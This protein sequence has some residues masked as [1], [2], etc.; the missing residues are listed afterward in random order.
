MPIFRTT[1][2]TALLSVLFMTS[3]QAATAHLDAGADC[4]AQ[5]GY[6]LYY[7]ET[8]WAGNSSTSSTTY[9]VCPV[10]RHNTTS[11]SFSA[12]AYIYSYSSSYPVSCRLRS[13]APT[14]SSGYTSTYTTSASSG[15]QTLSISS[16]TS[17]SSYREIMYCSIAQSPSSSDVTS[18]RSYYVSE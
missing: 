17:G 16:T 14:S 2:T 18:L 10:D 5:A 15:Y 12:Y 3:S 9:A 4:V 7:S 11:S 13:Y 1:L 8:G 6:S